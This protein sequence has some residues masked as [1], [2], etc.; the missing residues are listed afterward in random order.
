MEITGVLTAGKLLSSALEHLGKRSQ[1]DETGRSQPGEMPATAF[2][3]AAPTAVQDIAARYDLTRIS[4]Q[5]FS[6][7]IRRLYEAGALTDQQYQELSQIRVDL[8]QE[9]VDP[10]ETLN[11]IQFYLAKLRK[12]Q[13]PMEGMLSVGKSTAAVASSEVAAAERRLQWL[14]KFAAIQTAPERF[15]LDAEA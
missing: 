14:Q 4:P 2:G 3:A 15:G 5:E 11:L 10:D 9:H 1:T 13:G 12:L 6:E 8:D 7:M